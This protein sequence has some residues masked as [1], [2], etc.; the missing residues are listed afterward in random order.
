MYFKTLRLVNF[1]NYKEKSFNLSPRTLIVGK[2]GAGKS[3]LLEAL[4]LVVSGKSFRGAKNQNLVRNGQDRAA[5]QVET[6]NEKTS[7]FRISIE[8]NG[9]DGVI[10]NLFIDSKKRNVLDVLGKTPTVIFAPEHLSIVWD[11]PKARRNFLNL[12]IA[13]CDTMYAKELF[14]LSKVLKNRNKLFF[15]IKE[16]GADP[17]E[18][19]F[20]NK[21]LIDLGTKITSSRIRV[22]NEFN[23]KIKELYRKIS[24]SDDKLEVSYES[25]VWGKMEKLSSQKK[26]R[27]EFEAILES[28]EKLEIALGQSLYGPHRDDPKIF[29]NDQPLSGVG[30]RGEVRSA[31][32]AL[33]F[34]EFE[35]LK[36]HHDTPPA[37]LFDDVFS[38]LDEKRAEFL[39]K[40]LPGDNQLIFTAIT[41]PKQLEGLGF[42]TI[43]LG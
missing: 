32:I 34:A 18:L 26:L 17:S 1:R 36:N 42:K 7:S 14:R 12:L 41:P 27:E 10:K 43:N 4:F 3:N 31:V 38:E 35:Y 6:S 13:Q 19:L 23:K 21:E 11:V 2:N 15:L 29:I 9:G 28:K 33:K 40:N 22:I 30:S 16:T 20:W 37:F 24:N 5:V 8:P 39:V 25:T